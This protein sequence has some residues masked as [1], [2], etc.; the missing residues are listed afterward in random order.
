ML[1]ISTFLELK[2]KLSP[3][4]SRVSQNF[5]KVSASA[6][7]M[8]AGIASAE[9]GFGRLS[10]AMASIAAVTGVGLS[11]KAILDLGAQFE[12]TSL[13]IAGNIKAFDLAPTFD[14]ARK[15]ATAALGT[16][17]ALAA[18]LPGEAEDYVQ[19]FRTALPKAI[20][21]GLGSV[22]KV[23]DFTSRYAAVAISNQIDAAQAGMDLARILGGQAGL[24]VRTWT[25]LNPHIKVTAELLKKMGPKA[26]GLAVGTSLTA[27]QFNKLDA[28]TRRMLVQDAIGKFDDSITAASSTFSAKMGEM[29]S[30]VRDLVLVG[31]EPMF[32]G[33]KSSLDEINKALER[34]RAALLRIGREGSSAMASAI[35]VG[36]KGTTII[37]DNFDAVFTAVKGIGAAVIGWRIAPAV[38]GIFETAATI[39][40]AGGPAA[41]LAGLTGGVVVLATAAG[42]AIGEG[43]IAVMK[44]MGTWDTFV[45]VATGGAYGTARQRERDIEA[46][47]SAARLRFRNDITQTLEGVAP[48]KRLAK[49]EEFLGRAKGETSRADVL[50]VMRN[51]GLRPAAA[52][53]LPKA[54][55]AKTPAPYNDFRNSRF[56]I[57]QEFAE[58]FDPDR[59]AVAFASDLAR[60]GEMRV[61]SALAPT[62]GLVR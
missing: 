50:E 35:D 18:K 57:T 26:R 49:A 11:T 21:S 30:R 40:G 59:I 48:G 8:R 53:K 34:N 38:V 39:I 19:V 44:K 13:S 25:T 16:I 3:G 12:D 37:L 46:E 27:E 60:I 47:S 14:E 4:L 45:D 17:N 6:T 33:A 58:G 15:S 28:V 42:Y 20:E 55:G 1:N 36:V 51:L 61:Q 24:D 43:M 5:G 56:N 62:A 2:D 32:E 10:G 41:W 31:S 9:A 23:A 54:P 7:K 22:Q 52:G 29:T